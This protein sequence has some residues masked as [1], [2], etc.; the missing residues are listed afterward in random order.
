MIPRSVSLAG[1]KQQAIDF[2][3]ERLNKD[4]KEAERETTI[5]RRE[6]MELR[7]QLK[8]REEYWR[9]Q[10]EELKKEYEKSRQLPV[11]ETKSALKEMFDAIDAMGK[12]IGFE[13]APEPDVAESIDTA[14]PLVIPT[15]SEEELAEPDAVEVVSA[16]PEIKEDASPAEQT[17]EINLVNDHEQ[18]K[19]DLLSLIKS[20]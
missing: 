4:L 6:V 13:Q 16:P 12:A 5:A 9:I 19:D 14:Q 7:K 8:E 18:L 10:Y 17:I 15:P 20:L 1:Q 3:I 11:N 2:T